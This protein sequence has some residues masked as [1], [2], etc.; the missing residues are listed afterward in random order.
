MVSHTTKPMSPSPRRRKPLHNFTLPLPKWGIQ[1][2]LTCSNT[3]IINTFG[4]STNPSLP[5]WG[6][7]RYLRCSNTTIINTAGAS[8]NPSKKDMKPPITI[9]NNVKHDF[10]SPTRVDGTMVGNENVSSMLRRN[11]NGNKIWH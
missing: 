1:R 4:A 8:T 9:S 3:A 10:T 11:T 7:Q 2:I 5:K 6:I